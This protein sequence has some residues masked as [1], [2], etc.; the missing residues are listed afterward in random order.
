M[1][2]R[3]QELYHRFEKSLESMGCFGPEPFLAVGVSGGADSLALA[4]F[5]HLWCQARGGKIVALSVN[6]HLRPEADQEL[7]WVHQ[8]LRSYGIQHEILHWVFQEKPQTAI[9]E[10]AR[11]ARYDLMSSWCQERGI[12]YLAVAHHA[13]DQ[14]ETFLLRLEKK[15]HLGGLA[16]MA[17]LS[18]RRSLCL[19]RPFLN[20]TK[21]E[22]CIIAEKVYREWI[23]D[24]SNLNLDFRRIY[25]RRKIE[26]SPQTFQDIPYFIHVC[27]EIREE[28]EREMSVYWAYHSVLHPSGWL[29]MDWSVFQNLKESTQRSILGR[30][31]QRIGSMNTP[32]RGESLENL[33]KALKSSSFSLEKK[34]FTLSRCLVY[35]KGNTVRL[36]RENRNLSAPQFLS[37]LEHSRLSPLTWDRFQIS[38][39]FSQWEKIKQEKF[40]V[41]AAGE[42]GWDLLS[43]KQKETLKKSFM[44]KAVPSC[45]FLWR[46]GKDPW[47]PHFL[48]SGEEEQEPNHF[49]SCE[50][51]PLLPLSEAKGKELT[52]L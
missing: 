49:F 21:E 44:R 31:L 16:A 10:K 48:K 43:P 40:F 18:Y 25:W 35:K 14:A 2:L 13:Q 3:I 41:G 28:T 4:Y 1:S 47:L 7:Q 20:F 33:W 12:L 46:E 39:S 37:S 34:P 50:F 17:A 51:I 36:Y 22:I 19:L 8:T 24:P 11:Q 32:P 23:H 26:S 29:Q 38:L 52:L 6:H 42:K 5:S 27:R 9:Q 15:S 45:P 30:A